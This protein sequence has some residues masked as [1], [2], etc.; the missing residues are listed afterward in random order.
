MP[1]SIC[2][3]IRPNWFLKA[4]FIQS[5]VIN[6]NFWPKSDNIYSDTACDD[7]EPAFITSHVSCQKNFGRENYYLHR[8]LTF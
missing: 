1:L 3:G 7:L 4:K 5:I 2:V 8:T 6:C